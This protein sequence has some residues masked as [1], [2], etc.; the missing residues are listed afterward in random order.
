VW[1]FILQSDIR[2]VMPRVFC[3]GHLPPELLF[4]WVGRDALLIAGSFIKRVMER[5]KGSAFFDT[6]G[7]ATFQIMPNQLSKVGD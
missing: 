5:P 3:S 7:T 4:V 1:D 2:V 6:T